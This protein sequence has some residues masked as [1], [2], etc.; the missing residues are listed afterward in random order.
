MT[1]ELTTITQTKT[2]SSNFDFSEINQLGKVLFESGYFADVKSMAQAVVKILAG[3]EMGIDPIQSMT[4][5][6]IINGKPVIGS[7]LM[8][9][10]IKSSGK[11]NYH[12]K[13]HDNTICIIEFFENGKLTGETSF[14]IEDAKKAGTKNLDK[15]PKNMLFAR[16]ISNGL[17]F[18][19]P[20]VLN[21]LV[22]YVPEEM[23]HL[24]ASKPV[25]TITEIEP[26]NDFK[27]TI[28][29]IR[30]FKELTAFYNDNKNILDG[31]K[32]L[33]DHLQSKKDQ[34]YGEYY[35]KFH[36]E[37]NSLENEAEITELKAKYSVLYKNL[38]YSF[39][40]DEAIKQRLEIL[41]IG[42]KSAKTKTKKADPD[43]IEE[44]L[45]AIT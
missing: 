8:A 44:A 35:D 21:G 19:C 6:H 20:D 22:A 36:A 10:K 38:E 42:Q 16:A 24:E 14:S 7:N 37:L 17:K 26:E 31:N 5:I 9:V 33:M 45:T 27:S 1:N 34:I 25:T 41:A 4:G 12:I 43:L 30:S 2:L 39:T 29:S 40:I 23:E 13:K 11:Y 28:D 3:R 32:D 18:Y 15:F